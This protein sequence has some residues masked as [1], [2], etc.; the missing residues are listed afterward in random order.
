MQEARALAEK[1]TAVHFGEGGSSDPFVIV[2]GDGHAA[3][4]HEIHLEGRGVLLKY[5]IAWVKEVRCLGEGKI[6]V[7]VRV[8]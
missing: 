1:V 3:V 6:E 4:D 8:V 7:T 5:T 2:F